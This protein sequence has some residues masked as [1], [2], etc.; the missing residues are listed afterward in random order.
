MEKG[1][2]PLTIMKMKIKPHGEA[3]TGPA[4]WPSCTFPCLCPN[5]EQQRI[6][7]GH[8]CCWHKL[9][10]PLWKVVGLRLVKLKTC[11]RPC[12]MLARGIHPGGSHGRAH[13]DTCTDS[14]QQQSWWRWH[15]RKSLTIPLQLRGWTERMNIPARAAQHTLFHTGEYGPGLPWWSSG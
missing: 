6:Q 15:N 2:I 11:P 9:A 8:P 13:Q 5:T 1:P 14:A 7:A 4:G 12:Q 10:Q 3:S